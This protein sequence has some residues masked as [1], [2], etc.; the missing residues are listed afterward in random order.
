M[1]MGGQTLDVDQIPYQQLQRK[2]KSIM[3]ANP[4]VKIRLNSTKVELIN[5]VKKNGINTI[6][7]YTSNS[8]YQYTKDEFGALFFYDI[9]VPGGNII[10]NIKAII[11]SIMESEQ[12]PDNTRIQIDLI[13]GSSIQRKNIC[14]LSELNVEIIE[15][16]FDDS[17]MSHY[18]SKISQINLKFMPF[19]R[20]GHIANVTTFEDLKKK[21]CI[22]EII[23]PNDQMCAVRASLVCLYKMLNHEDYTKM[24]KG[25]DYKLQRVESEKICAA[26]R[27]DIKTPWLFD[28]LNKLSEYYK[29]T[30]SINDLR[31]VIING[32]AKLLYD[33]SGDTPGNKETIRLY[34][35]HFNNHFHA[36]VNPQGMKAY[37]H[38]CSQCHWYGKKSMHNC[39]SNKCLT[40]D[41]RL[42]NRGAMCQ[43]CNKRLCD[44]C[45]HRCGDVKR[46][47]NEIPLTK[48]QVKCGT[49]HQIYNN[50]DEHKC[51]EKKCNCCQQLVNIDKHQC[52]VQQ[53]ELKKHIDNICVFDFECSQDN[54][55][56]KHI[57]V[58]CVARD[59][60]K[61]YIFYDIDSFCEWMFNHYEKQQITF[62]AHNARGYDTHFILNWLISKGVKP[63]VIMQVSKILE[64]KY[65][66]IRIIDSLSHINL[67]LR[68]FPQAFGIEETKKGYFPYKWISK[69]NNGY[70]GKMPDIEDFENHDKEF[71]EWYEKQDKNNWD[72]NKELLEYCQSDVKL[73]YETCI[74]FRELFNSITGSDPF[75]Y[76]TNASH[77]LNIYTSLFMPKDSIPIIPDEFGKQYKQSKKEK[78]W[79]KYMEQMTGKEIKPQWIGK[80]R[81]DGFDGEKI[82]QFH[83]CY[84]HGC[85]ECFPSGSNTDNKK[86]FDVLYKTTMTIE[87]KLKKEY[88]V[89]T[90]WEHDFDNLA[91][92]TDMPE[93][94]DSELPLR[95]RDAMFGGRT[96]TFISFAENIKAKY[97]DFTSLY[98]FVQSN[99]LYPSG[100]RKII[101][102]PKMWNHEWFGFAKITITPP[103][104]LY[105]PV[106]PNKSE[107]L[108]FDLNE[109]TGTW[110]TDE[111]NLAIGK[112][113]KIKQIYEVWHYSEKRKD[114][115]SEYVNVFLKIKQE[116]SGYPDWVKSDEDKDKYIKDYSDRQHILLEKDKITKNPGLRFI[117]KLCLNSLWGKFGQNLDRNDI[118]YV[119]DEVEYFRRLSDKKLK[120]CDNLNDKLVVMQIGGEQIPNYKTSMCIAAF[121]TTH[122]RLKLYNLMDDIIK[123][124]GKI[125]YCDTD[126][127]IFEG[128]DEVDTG[129]LLGELTSELN[130]DEYITSF[131]STGAKA[132]GY[133]TNKGNCPIKMKGISKTEFSYNDLFKLA[134]NEIKKIGNQKT[135]IFKK[136]IHHNIYTSKGEKEIKNTLDKRLFKSDGTSLPFGYEK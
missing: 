114:L 88:A 44:K 101:K 118:I 89:E 49:C 123:K 13:Y 129:E 7:K 29:T 104:D 98:P 105:L 22:V 87:A 41:E 6:P 78:Q 63:K 39:Y 19:Q 36:V 117:A 106:L 57:P 47:Y 4:K 75:A 76:I 34:L 132:Y 69:E 124:D 96:E 80:Y 91:K 107:K 71:I 93:I 122:A 79:I 12:L 84:W 37:E 25:K 70:V 3:K 135:M 108:L 53:T 102:N 125:Y 55:K 16:T 127:V 133:I 82:Y 134:Q 26:L 111:I 68:K 131:A 23:N 92:T 67:P 128:A 113:Y 64:L 112:G 81:V 73:L 58:L 103:T 52:Y 35:L 32:Q 42:H 48:D 121:T 59:K 45:K 95:P 54:E 31:I 33:T 8:G 30:Y 94:D 72:Y 65:K 21:R 97:Y 90:I 15:S 46:I 18:F 27:H 62:I 110:C 43:R 126:S 130:E 115:F 99:C 5:F 20:G 83:G 51:Y 116:S 24:R 28:D 38:F 136:D 50:N 61:E 11:N 56:S 85:R 86:S 100:E 2:A 9:S 77:C 1:S 66:N 40:C 14:T 74:K 60:E 120:R 119:N 17:G 10:E 109:K